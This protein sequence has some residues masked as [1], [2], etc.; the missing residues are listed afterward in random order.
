MTGP[1]QRHPWSGWG[2]VICLLAALVILGCL[3]VTT[4]TSHPQCT[5]GVV[6]DGVC[7][8]E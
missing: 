1:I 6:I 3:I 2:A 7:W 4:A 8:S 5:S